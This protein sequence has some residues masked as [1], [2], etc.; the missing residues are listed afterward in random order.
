MKKRIK[1]KKLLS[2]IT[3]FMAC[4]MLSISLTENPPVEENNNVPGIVNESETERPE[5]PAMPLD[6]GD[7]LKK[8]PI[9]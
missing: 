5:P 7:K 1:S 9:E 3:T 2:G 6:D 8:D 4:F